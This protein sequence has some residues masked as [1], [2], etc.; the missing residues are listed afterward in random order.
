LNDNLTCFDDEALDKSENGR[1]TEVGE[2]GAN[3]DV[4]E[5]EEEEDDDDEE[6]E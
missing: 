2:V 5:E 4:G 1:E 6:M 3:G